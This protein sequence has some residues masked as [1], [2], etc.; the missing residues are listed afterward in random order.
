MLVSGG[1]SEI[2]GGRFCTVEVDLDRRRRVPAS[3]DARANI[4][5]ITLV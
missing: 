3:L 1:G 4:R 5:S 2:D